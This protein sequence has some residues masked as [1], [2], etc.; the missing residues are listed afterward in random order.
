[1]TH[2]MKL[3]QHPFEMIRS[4]QKT[5]EIRLNDEKRQRIK[6]DDYI[7]FTQIETKGNCWQK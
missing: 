5:I 4:G 7:E 2:H 3:V 6:L 1:M